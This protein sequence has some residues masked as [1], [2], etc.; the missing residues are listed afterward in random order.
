EVLCRDEFSG[1]AVQD[2]EETVLISLHE[3]LAAR[4]IDGYI[5]Q[6]QLL[7][8]VEVPFLSGRGLEVPCIFPSICID[9]HDRREKPI[10]TLACAA[11]ALIPFK[12]VADAEIDEV[13]LG[14]V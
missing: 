11:P 5:R 7:H 6:D 2:V 1:L 9:G 4:S 13:K 10:V 12:P 8:R 14:V 3:D